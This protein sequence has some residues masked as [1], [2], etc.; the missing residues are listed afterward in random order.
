MLAL[1]V[2]T[3][4]VQRQQYTASHKPV[5]ALTAV[6][7]CDWYMFQIVPTCYRISIFT[8]A[9]PSTERKIPPL[10]ANLGTTII[11]G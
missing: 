3:S 5:I 6:K 7:M 8:H 11:K 4:K 9:L 1:Y 2:H 10:K